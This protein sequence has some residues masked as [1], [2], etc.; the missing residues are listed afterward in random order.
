MMSTRKRMFESSNENS[1]RGISHR[2][3][4][5]MGVSM[6]KAGSIKT[7]TPPP[8]IEGIQVCV[9]VKP[10]EEP[11][12]FVSSKG[13]KVSIKEDTAC[14]PTGPYIEKRCVETLDDLAQNEQLVNCGC[15]TFVDPSTG[16]ELCI[17]TATTLDSKRRKKKKKEK[18]KVS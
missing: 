11:E 1:F 7:T 9:A 14:A 16:K 6:S 4:M 5:S 15:C 18:V 17:Q 13:S 2:H 8:P 12:L 3:L 10:V